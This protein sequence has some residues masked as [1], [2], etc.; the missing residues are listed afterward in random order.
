ILSNNISNAVTIEFKD[1]LGEYDGIIYRVLDIG[2]DPIRLEVKSVAPERSGEC[3]LPDEILLKGLSWNGELW[4][5]V[6]ARIGESAFEN[7]DNLAEVD[8][9][10]EVKSIG[11]KAV[12]SKKISPES[13]TI[14]INWKKDLQVDGYQIQYAKNSK[15]TN[16]K[17]TITINK[18]ST[19]TKRF[20]N[21]SKVRNIMSVF[22]HTKNKW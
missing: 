14:K 21:L 2:V 13:K 15:F 12:I 4:N 1:G 10:L 3:I 9:K 11:E 5:A 20:Q 22:V 6:I 7:F 18:K 19:V 8:I 16:G 17:N